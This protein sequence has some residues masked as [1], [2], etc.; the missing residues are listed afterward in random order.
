MEVVYVVCS[1]SLNPHVL[2]HFFKRR[3]VGARELTL[4][5]LAKLDRD[6]RDGAILNP[7]A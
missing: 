5:I 6:G 1:F 7:A 3:P 2:H 4:A